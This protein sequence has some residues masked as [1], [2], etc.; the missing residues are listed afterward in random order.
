MKSR[1]ELQNEIIEELLNQ[2][3]YLRKELEATKKYSTENIDRVLKEAGIGNAYIIPKPV[4]PEEL[5]MPLETHDTGPTVE[6]EII[7]KSLGL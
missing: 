6:G 2:I 5:K 7:E 4:I 3:K 1:I